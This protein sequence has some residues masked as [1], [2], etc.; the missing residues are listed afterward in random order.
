[1]TAND[2]RQPRSTLSLSQVELG[3]L[4]GTAGLYQLSGIWGCCVRSRHT[5]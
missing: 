5:P 2:S 4:N 1:M 3:V